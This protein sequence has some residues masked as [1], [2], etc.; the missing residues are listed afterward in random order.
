MHVMACKGVASWVYGA[1]VWILVRDRRL[2]RTQALR[3]NRLNR[4]LSSFYSGL[5]RPGMSRS[6]PLRLQ[7]LERDGEVALDGPV[8]QAAAAR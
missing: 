2:G 6:P 8:I 4:M 7:D 1:V 3:L 5:Q